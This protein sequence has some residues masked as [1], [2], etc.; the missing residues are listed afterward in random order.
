VHYRILGP[1][2][3]V[4]DGTAKPLGPAKERA[5]LGILL[6][7]ANQVVSTERLVD[8]L[9][10]ENPP[11]SAP[12]VVQVYVSQLRKRLDASAQITTQPPGYVVTVGADDLDAVRFERLVAEARALADA[13]D[14]AAAVDRFDSALDLWRGPVLA[15]VIFESFAANEAERLEELRVAALADR[16]DCELARGR[17]DLVV[18]DLETLVAEHPLRERFRAQL[19]LALY[20][21]GR[22]ADALAVYQEGRRRLVDELGIEPGSA[23]QQLERSILRQERALEPP[24]R[25][26]EQRPRRRRALT[27]AVLIC[28]VVGTGAFA[29]VTR[30]PDSRL[31]LEPRS[32]GKIDEK[33]NTIV[34]EIAVGSRPA[35]IAADK[36]TVWV[37]GREGTLSRID[38]SRMRVVTTRPLD[39][40]PS[41]LTLGANALWVGDARRNSV[42]RVDLAHDAVSD[43]LPLAQP[44][45]RAAL[46]GSVAPS[47]AFGDGSLWV[48]RGQT[49]VLRLNPRTHRVLGDIRPS[50]GAGG[51][52]AFGEDALWV[53]GSNAVSRVSPVLSRVMSTIRLEAMPVALAAGHGSIWVALATAGKVARVDTETEA[54][55]TI[56]VGGAPTALAVDRAAVWVVVPSEGAVLRIDP[57]R[58]AVVAR[59][60]T[61]ATPTAV[62]VAGDSV[63]V[64]VT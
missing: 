23:L 28:A 3:V 9:W 62:A 7:H 21:A 61:G 30:S 48:S 11:R 20:R 4:V 24:A 45:A 35:F 51:A 2:E 55:E 43:R 17:H 25:A 19:M 13:G 6:L 38:A 52:I 53:G 36:R 47:L 57:D 16:I 41:G 63:W 58:N 49:N 46:L 26:D 1:L 59:I 12:K 44:S 54:V 29:L 37:A 39:A 64:A 50:R 34:G 14:P 42:V 33:G 32:V 22:Q 60:V 31:M 10:G 5:L 18:G 8:E 15:D 56:P 27:A 40:Q